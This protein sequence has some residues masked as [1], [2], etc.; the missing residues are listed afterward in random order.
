MVLAEKVARSSQGWI[1]RTERREKSPPVQLIGWLVYLLPAM[2]CWIWPGMSFADG[3]G[4][5]PV[6]N[7][8]PTQLLFLGMPGDRATV[9]KRG[10]LDVR[11]EL[12]D[13][14][15]VF[16]EKNPQSSAVMKLETLRSGLFLRYGLTDRLEVAMEVPALYRFRG[17]LEGVITMTERATTGLAPV[18]KA[19]QQTGYAYTVSQGGNT[20]F[21]GGQDQ[22][23][24]GD[25]SFTSK[26]QLVRQSE[27]LPAISM[28]VAV[29]APT[30]D[31]SRVFGSGHPDVGVGLAIEK[32]FA[33]RWIVY[34]NAN[35][36]FPTGQVA[37]L[38]P[39]P[40]FSSVTAL[41]YLWSDHVSFTAQFDYY[42]SAFH[43]TGIRVLDRG[44]TELVAGFSYRLRPNLLWQ[45]YGVENVDFITGGAADFTLSTVVMYRFES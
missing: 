5:F 35:E 17:T 30:G 8:Q 23:G 25:M 13:T 18:R 1:S 19:L 33:S 20:L 7:F 42:S 11:I 15:T 36:M 27:T 37:G 40:V 14:S 16:N 28:R 34:V 9:L 45:V 38:H 32:T 43:G 26:Y 10:T 44:V 22:L 39:Q 41:E 31:A 6:R 2:G 21:R 4:P 24:L 12:A 3:F 29:K